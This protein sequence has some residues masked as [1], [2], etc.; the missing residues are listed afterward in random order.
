MF[1]RA[2]RP[3][4]IARVL[5]IAEPSTT[6]ADEVLQ[7]VEWWRPSY[8]AARRLSDEQ[9]AYLKQG[10]W[11]PP[12]I[13]HQIDRPAPAIVIAAAR[14]GLHDAPIETL[15][16]EDRFSGVQSACAAQRL[17][18][19]C[20]R[21]TDQSPHHGSSPRCR[22]QPAPVEPAKPRPWDSGHEGG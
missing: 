4:V 11:W 2:Y 20:H 18:L 19:P 10:G 5:E 16:G 9:R 14:P 17:T 1:L 3:A 8:R 12:L 15:G 21:Q 7:W 13:A 6:I 22:H